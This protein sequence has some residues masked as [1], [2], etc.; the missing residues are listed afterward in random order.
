MIWLLLGWQSEIVRHDPRSIWDLPATNAAL[1]WPRSG[2]RAENGL[3]I[4]MRKWLMCTAYSWSFQVMQVQ[5][6]IEMFQRQLLP[7]I[8]SL[9]FC[10]Q[11]VWIEVKMKKWLLYTTFSRTL[12]A[13]PSKSCMAILQDHSKM[14]WQLLL[15][16]IQ[17]P[18]LLWPRFGNRAENGLQIGMKNRLL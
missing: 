8:Q 10:D 6:Q 13:Q 4:K 15:L 1:L 16:R 5:D 12:W 18:A 11:E 2:N 3:R 9:I 14:Q 7:R 17:F